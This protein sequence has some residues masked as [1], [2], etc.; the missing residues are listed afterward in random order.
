MQIDVVLSP[1]KTQMLQQMSKMALTM[2][3]LRCPQVPELLSVEISCH[4][5][6]S[7][8][9]RQKRADAEI[10]RSAVII[11]RLATLDPLIPLTRFLL[12]CFD[13]T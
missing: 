6:E 7:F 11:L 2:Q 4:F 8:R 9:S 3:L 10:R 13:M 5:L 12:N 1:G